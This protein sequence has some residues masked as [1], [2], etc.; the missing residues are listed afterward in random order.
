MQGDVFV[1]RRTSDACEYNTSPMDEH[2]KEEMCA[3]NIKRTPMTIEDSK[4]LPMQR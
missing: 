1:N 3:C 2:V 4:H